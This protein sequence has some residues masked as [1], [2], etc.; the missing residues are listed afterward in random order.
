MGIKDKSLE[1]VLKSVAS[2]NPTPGGGSVSAVAG[3]FAASLVE[4]VCNLTIG[5]EKY[6]ENESEVKKIKKLVNTLTSELLVLSDED[7][8]A[9]DGVVKAFKTNKT[10]KNRKIIIQNAFKKAT[11]IPLETGKKSGEVLTFAER[12]LE[13][14]NKNASSDSL[15]ASYLSKAA[16]K[17]ALENV[18]INLESITDEAFKKELKPSIIL[19]SSKARWKE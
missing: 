15:V 4:M 6:I 16:I 3:A 5:K 1:E 10:N 11:L 7:A 13:I 18:E 17:G 19:L 8:N 9:Y 2:K 12:M 14:G